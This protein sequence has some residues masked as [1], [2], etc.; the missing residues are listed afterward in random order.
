MVSALV[1]DGECPRRRRRRRSPGVLDAPRRRRA[2]ALRSERGPRRPSPTGP[3]GGDARRAA[4]EVVRYLR[5]RDAGRRLL[6]PPLLLRRRHVWAARSI[7]VRARS[8]RRGRA[9]DKNPDPR[10]LTPPPPREPRL[11]S[12]SDIERV[13]RRAAAVRFP[14]FAAAS[15]L[16]AFVSAASPPSSASVDVSRRCA[17]THAKERLGLS[18]GLRRSTLRRTRGGLRRDGER[19]RVPVPSEASPFARL[20]HELRGLR[21]QFDARAR[22]HARLRGVSAAAAGGAREAGPPRCRARRGSTRAPTRTRRATSDTRSRHR[23]RPQRAGGAPRPARGR[24]ARGIDRRGR[25]GRGSLGRAPPRVRRR[26]AGPRRAR[27]RRPPASAG[28]AS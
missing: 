15:L 13:C 10:R 26:T 28:G 14:R 25:T 23:A 21:D 4:P 17:V 22:A 27:P 18:R 24:D 19:P 3:P 12:A 6:P 5:A 16:R 9:A 8:C 7:W 11:V 1:R 2:G 20:E